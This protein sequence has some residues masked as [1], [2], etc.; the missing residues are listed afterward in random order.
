MLNLRMKILVVQETVSCSDF[1][2]LKR[3][4]KLKT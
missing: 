3:D 1:F 2:E 4:G